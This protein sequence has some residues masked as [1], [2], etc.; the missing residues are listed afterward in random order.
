MSSLSILQR[1][2]ASRGYKVTRHP[3]E[4]S[5]K[6]N[7]LRVIR[8]LQQLLKSNTIKGI[9]YVAVL[10]IYDLAKQH[11]KGRKLTAIEQAALATTLTQL[12]KLHLFDKI[13]GLFKSTTS[14]DIDKDFENFQHWMYSPIEDGG[15]GEEYEE[16]ELE[17]APEQKSRTFKWQKLATSATITIDKQ[18][19]ARIFRI[20]RVMLKSNVIRGALLT[21]VYGI[22]ALIAKAVAQRKLDKNQEVALRDSFAF[23]AKSPKVSRTLK[24]KFA[25]LQVEIDEI[26]SQESDET[27]PAK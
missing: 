9:G 13:K 5:S 16:D 26:F 11:A 27:V 25:E 14:E 3:V 21:T 2:L 1:E 22:T 10:G 8:A 19:V 7:A 4:A 6:S 18:A 24:N 23:V 15:L 12:K 17:D 20:L